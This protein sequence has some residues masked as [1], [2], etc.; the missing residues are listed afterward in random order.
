MIP[1]LIILTFAYL[2]VTIFAVFRGAIV[3]AINGVVDN[4][5]ESIDSA[6]YIKKAVT[7]CWKGPR[8]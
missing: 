5:G 7:I 2:V 6:L 4:I 3:G 8:S 1:V